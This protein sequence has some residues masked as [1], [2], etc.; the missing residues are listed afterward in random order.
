[1][2]QRRVGAADARHVVVEQAGDLVEYVA[3]ADA[4]ISQQPSFAHFKQR[5]RAS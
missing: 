5:H 3:A 4:L 2:Q 1:M